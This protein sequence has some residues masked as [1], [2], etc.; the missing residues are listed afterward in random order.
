MAFFEGELEEAQLKAQS[1]LSKKKLNES[2]M[3]MP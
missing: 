3:E 1:N 2:E